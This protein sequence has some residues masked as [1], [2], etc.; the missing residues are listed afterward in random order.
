MKTNLTSLIIMSLLMLSSYTSAAVVNHNIATGCLTIP[1]SSTDEY[2]ITGSTTSNYVVVEFGW[3]GTITLKN[4][5]F[6]FSYSSNSPIRITGKNDLL[7]TDPSRTNVNL[8]LD[9]DNYIYNDG[10][11]SACIQVD[12][13]AQINISAIEPCNNASG[14]LTALQATSNGGAAIGS[15]EDGGYYGGKETSATAVLS[16]GYTGI[17]AGGNIIISSGTIKARGG[18]GAGI[19]GGYGTWYDGMIVIYGGVVEA[20]TIRH[21]AG[22]GSGCPDGSGVE[23]A[24]APNS[25]IVVL[26]PAVVTASGATGNEYVD[27]PELALA[28]T[29][30]RVYIGD[31]NQ[32]TISVKTIDNLPDANVYFDLS[33]DPDINR[34]VSSTVDPTVLNVNNVLLGKTNASGVFTTTGSLMNSTTFFTD[35]TNLAGKLYMPVTQTLPNGGS[36]VFPLLSA[37]FNIVAMPSTMLEVGYSPSDAL[38]SAT[39]LKLLYNDNQ[40]MTNVVFDLASGNTSTF[41]APIFLAADSTTVVSAPTTLNKGDIYYIVVPIQNDQEARIHSDVLRISAKWNGSPT[42]YIRQVVNQIIAD[43]RVVNICEGESYYF[44]GEYLTESGIYAEVSTESSACATSSSLGDAIKLVVHSPQSYDLHETICANE[45]YNFGGE[46]Y[47]VSGVYTKTFANQYGCDSIVTLHLTVGGLYDVTLRDTICSGETY[48]WDGKSYTSAGVYTRKYASVLGCDSIVTL[49]LFVPEQYD[50]HLYDTIC[51]G[52]TYVWNNVKYTKSGSYTQPFTSQHGC[53]SI[54]TVHLFIAPIVRE[55]YV[56][57]ICQDQPYTFGKKILTQPGTYVDTTLSMYGCDSITTLTLRVHEP[58][59]ID[60]Y[61]EVCHDDTFN[62]RGQ[63]VEKPGIYYD[64]LLTQHGCDS[65]YRLIFNKTPT[66][67]FHSEDTMCVGSTYTYRGKLLTQPGTYYDSLTTVSGCDSIYRL[68]LHTHPTY[69]IYALQTEDVCGDASTYEMVVQYDGA[70][71]SHYNLLYSEKAKEQGFR[72]I[73]L[74]PFVNDTLNLP[75]PHATPYVRPDYYDVTLQL[76]NSTCPDVSSEHE[77]D[78][79]VRYPS[80]IIEQNWQDVVAVKNARYNGGYYFQGY[81]WHVNNVSTTQTD[82]YLYLPS[83]Q[84]GDEV[85]LYATRMGEDYAVPTCPIVIEPQNVYE[86]E[87]PVPVYPTRLTRSN[88]NIT[89]GYANTDS[90]YYVYDVLGRQL[91]SGVCGASEKAVLEL[92]DV[93]GSYFVMIIDSS[94]QKQVVHVMVE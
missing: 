16:D 46:F 58:Y 62:F 41:S 67:L 15:R 84:V 45:R 93:S 35:A 82:S 51:Q 8:I 48:T 24:Y 89:I 2:V 11:G 17:T 28:G 18:H 3:K 7:N 91:A 29:K 39:V 38:Q 59:L 72:D 1:A 5:Y 70:R 36:V 53:D 25:A 44:N 69:L 37:N 77:T 49:N 57:A 83:L 90:Q 31:P 65:V 6:D 81:D 86:Q 68:V 21:S 60:Q 85:V 78:L 9:G 12:Q 79:L 34:V 27:V 61:I 76:I 52:E 43:L 88:R 22:I 19:G 10:G 33:Q 47:N 63:V 42:G 14:T 40:P 71:P 30:V 74:A 50:I 20:R 55:T 87:H 73:L 26:P 13:G 94:E 23:T 75:I 64:S 56:E 92:P 4:C 80:W 32:P 54:V 66:Y